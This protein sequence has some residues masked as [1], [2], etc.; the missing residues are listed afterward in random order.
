MGQDEEGSPLSEQA[1]WE[2]IVR[3]DAG[4]QAPPTAEAAMEASAVS[5]ENVARKLRGDDLIHWTYT[6]KGTLVSVGD[7]A[8]AHSVL[9]VPVNSF[10]G[11]A[12]RTLKKAVSTR[13]FAK[14]S[15][16]RRV[17]RSW[18]DM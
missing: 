15:G 13:W 14:I 2:A 17:L 7:D 4:N 6:D 12:A 11:P 5:G 16:P 3:P 8:V 18:P 10:S 9:G 1:I